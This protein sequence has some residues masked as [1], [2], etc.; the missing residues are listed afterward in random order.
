MQYKSDFMFSFNDSPMDNTPR[1]L[2]KYLAAQD[3]Q[4]GEI[5]SE[6]NLKRSTWKTTA[7]HFK[8]NYGNTK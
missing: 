5:Y 1:M 7:N 8:D 3:I 4:I 2:I 6:D